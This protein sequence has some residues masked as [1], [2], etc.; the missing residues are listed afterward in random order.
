VL[1][2]VIIAISSILSITVMQKSKQIGIL[3]AMGIKNRDA[4]L[5]FLYQG[6]LVGLT[7]SSIGTML[8]LGLLSAFVTFTTSPGGEPLFEI[9][10]GYGFIIRS[11]LIALGSATLAG[12]IPARRSLRL[13]PVDVIRGG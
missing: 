1:A 11:W 12:L 7:G 5:I 8:G 3:K 10:F 6:F 13:N 2:S 9:F 4:S